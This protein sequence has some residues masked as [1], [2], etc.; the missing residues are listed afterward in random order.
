VPNECALMLVRCPGDKCGMIIRRGD[1]LKHQAV[2]RPV[3]VR[4][5]EPPAAAVSVVTIIIIIV[6]VIMSVVEEC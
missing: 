2:C 1:L 5:E 3:P 6:I 4:V